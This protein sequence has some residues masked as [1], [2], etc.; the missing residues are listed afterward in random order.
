MS[1]IVQWIY[2]LGLT[3]WVGGI[4]FFSFFTTPT[5]FIQLPKEMASQFLAALFPKYYLLGYFCGGAMALAT[6][7]EAALV[8]QLP[9]IRL[10]V[11]ALMLGCS[12]YAGQVVRPQVHDLKVQMK[13][14]EEGTEIG[15][16]L[17]TRFDSLHRRS[18]MLN[19]LVLAG[20]LLLIGIVAYR[21]RL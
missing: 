15:N 10:L 18:V 11:L 20:G 9:W 21:L 19:V 3:L 17:K 6:L 1:F 13:S 14:V 7:V 8:K 5:V 2:L 4:V 12:I 16:T